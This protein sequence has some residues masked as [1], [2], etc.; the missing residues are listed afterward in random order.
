VQQLSLL[1][2]QSATPA[3]PTAQLGGAALQLPDEHVPASQV[4]PSAPSLHVPVLTPG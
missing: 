4:D 2:P 1:A 3:P